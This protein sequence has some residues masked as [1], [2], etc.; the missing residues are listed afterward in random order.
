MPYAIIRTGGKQYRVSVGDR[1][2]IEKL[3]AEVGQEV[4][5]NEVLA[6][7]EGA[8]LNADASTLAGQAVTAKVLRQGRAAKIR[9][10][11]YKRRKGFDRRQGHRQSYT[12]VQITALPGV[13]AA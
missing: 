4:A 12:E 6:L 1:L 3:D 9:I 2:R 5:L 10:Q 13:A 8:E 7:G 11:K